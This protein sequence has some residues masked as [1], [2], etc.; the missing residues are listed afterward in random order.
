VISTTAAGACQR[1]VKARHIRGSPPR[2]P[3]RPCTD[4]LSRQIARL[5]F[6]AAAAST[7]SWTTTCEVRGADHSRPSLAG[8]MAEATIAHG[9]E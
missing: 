5:P 8:Q 2:P 4:P 7:T 6:P 9:K 3:H 1:P